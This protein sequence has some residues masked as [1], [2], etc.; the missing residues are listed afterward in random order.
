MI[1]NNKLTPRAAVPSRVIPTI[2][3]YTTQAIPIVIPLNIIDAKNAKIK[4]AILRVLAKSL[5]NRGNHL[6][7]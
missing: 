7:T 3:L 4:T 1:K 2:G 6:T 5:P